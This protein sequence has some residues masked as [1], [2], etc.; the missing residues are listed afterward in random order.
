MKK[1]D[2]IYIVEDDFIASF[3]IKKVVDEH[4]VG[5]ESQVFAN[6][7]L[8]LDALLTIFENC[9][10][11]PDL[12]LL[13]INMPIM[14]GWEFLEALA[15]INKDVC[16]PVFILTSSISPADMERAQSFREVRGFFSKPISNEKLNEILAL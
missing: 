7:R 13:D 6:G 9:H 5:A 10:K 15:C 1:I 8:A 11:A 16:I 14:D 4:P 3:V 12:I 2:L